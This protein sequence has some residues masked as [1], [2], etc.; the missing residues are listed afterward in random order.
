MLGL[1]VP[2]RVEA[3]GGRRVA[4]KRNDILAEFARGCTECR[5]FHLQRLLSSGLISLVL[6]DSYHHSDPKQQR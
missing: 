3:S 6:Q 1:K 2:V 4:L 5:S